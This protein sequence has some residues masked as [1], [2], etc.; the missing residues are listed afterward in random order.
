MF[1]APLTRAWRRDRRGDWWVGIF[2]PWLLGLPALDFW[3]SMPATISLAMQSQLERL[4]WIGFISV[5]TLMLYL[6]AMVRTRQLR[7]YVRAMMRGESQLICPSCGYPWRHGQ[8]DDRST[9]P[10][11]GT[12]RPQVVADFCR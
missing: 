7:R 4:S 12:T 1:N 6:M 10:E 2:G 5:S 8:A 11:C 3:V 9:C